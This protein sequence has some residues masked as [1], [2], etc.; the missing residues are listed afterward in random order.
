MKTPELIDK[1]QAHETETNVTYME[2]NMDQETPLSNT[3]FCLCKF[4]NAEVVDHSS[5]H[6]LLYLYARKYAVYNPTVYINLN[7]EEE[8]VMYGKNKM[9]WTGAH[10]SVPVSPS[11]SKKLLEIVMHC[12][13]CGD[14]IRIDK[15]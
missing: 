5:W 1:Q 15:S 11:G 13:C 8:H 9:G 7:P 2:H 4:W 6:G 3:T 14:K 10:K 12:D